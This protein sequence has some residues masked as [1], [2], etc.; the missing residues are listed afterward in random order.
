MHIQ[1]FVK[2]MVN[3]TDFPVRNKEEHDLPWGGKLLFHN[4]VVGGSIDPR[5]M[6]AILKG[7]MERM[8][9]GPLTGSY[10]RDIAV[11]IYDGKMHPVDSN[12]ISFKL[13]GRFAFIT[14]FKNS[15]PKI[16]E[17]VYDVEVRLPEEMMGAAMTDLQGRRALI[18]GMESD[19][20]YQLIRAKVPL[21]EMHKYATTLSSITSG[22][23]TYSMK[24]DEYNSVPSDVQ[25]KLLKAYEEEQEEE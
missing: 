18:M 16:M 10:A 14:A 1:P 7:I 11:Y 17:P 20:K 22:R 24:F 3:P 8:E 19:G 15:G 4:C 2:D 12:E 5:F 13:A 6:P 21:A 23:G 9:R 25:D